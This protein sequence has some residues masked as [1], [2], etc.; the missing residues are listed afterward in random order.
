VARVVIVSTAAP[1]WYTITL[2]SNSSTNLGRIGF[3]TL[4]VKI[5]NNPAFPGLETFSIILL[6][7]GCLVIFFKKMPG[8]TG[9]H[10]S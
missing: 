4:R 6:L 8:R 10:I 2:D 5:D 9:R 1:N 3:E 7:A